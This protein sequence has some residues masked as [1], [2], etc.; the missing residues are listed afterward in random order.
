M[1]CT[2]NGSVSIVGRCAPVKAVHT[3]LLYAGYLIRLRPL[4]GRVESAFLQYQLLSHALRTQ[5]E[6]AAKS[7]SGVNNINSK[8]IR[9]LVIATC[10][11]DEQR[12]IVILLEE[13]LTSID[14]VE[15]DI[16]QNIQRA[17][18]LR[19]SILKKAFAGELVP[20]DP[21]DEPAAELLAR[22]RAEREAGGG[23]P[24]AGSKKANPKTASR[25]PKKTRQLPR[26][27]A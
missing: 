4:K 2:S 12:Q 7:T 3:H 24:R 1:R 5:I 22:I 8:E 16:T 13:K 25:L 21:N 18:A 17:E 14:S 20:Q 10:P 9:S 26:A 6:R 19:Q 11:L 15:S 27:G 23:A